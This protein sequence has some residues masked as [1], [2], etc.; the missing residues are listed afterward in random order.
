MA[1]TAK[2]AGLA[3]A[4]EP[5][6]LATTAA[7][8]V[9]VAASPASSLLNRHTAN[10]FSTFT[11]PEFFK[12]TELATGTTTSTTTTIEAQQPTKHKKQNSISSLSG[13]IASNSASMNFSSSSSAAAATHSNKPVIRHIT[14]SSTLASINNSNI[15]PANDSNPSINETLSGLI[16][17]P[18]DVWS[19]VI[20]R[21]IPLFNGEGH[22]GF[23]ED[24]NDFVSQHIHKTIADSPSKSIIKLHTDITEL[25][26]NGV[27]ILNNKLQ[28]DQLNDSKLLIKVL[29]VWHFFFTGVLP[30]LEAIFLPL[31][32]DQ[33]LLNMIE[34]KN[35]IVLQERIQ[36]LHLLQ[37]A[38]TPTSLLLRQSNKSTSQQQP[39]KNR[40]AHTRNDQEVIHGIDIRR[41]ALIAFREHLIVP[42]YSR[43]YKLFTMI[44][45]PSALSSSTTQFS[46]ETNS[47]EH[48]HLKRL[49]MIG[50]LCSVQT[51]DP[52]QTMITEFSKLIRFKK[53]NL[54]LLS[55]NNNIR[56]LPPRTASANTNAVPVSR[57]RERSESSSSSRSRSSPPQH[58]HQQTPRQSSATI[59]Q[60][61]LGLY[62]EEYDDD[63]PL[64]NL[65]EEENELHQIKGW[66]KNR[67]FA[68]RSIRR[69]LGRNGTTIRRSTRIYN[70]SDDQTAPVTN[71]PLT[72]SLSRPSRVQQRN[73][74]IQRS[75]PDSSIPNNPSPIVSTSTTSV[76]M[77]MTTS[78]GTHIEEEE[79]PLEYL[80][81]RVY[82]NPHSSQ[83]ESTTTAHHRTRIISSRNKTGSVSSSNG[84]ILSNLAPSHPPPTPSF[85]RNNNNTNVNSGGLS[86]KSTEEG[87]NPYSSLDSPQP[88]TS[89]T[90]SSSSKTPHRPIQAF[91]PLNPPHP[92]PSSNTTMPLNLAI[93]PLKL[94]HLRSRSSSGL[95][96]DLPPP[97][98]SSSTNGSGVFKVLPG[99]N[100]KLVISN[101]TPFHH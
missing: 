31:M 20:L 52:K 69:Q 47:T 4:T 65:L 58:Q 71:P 1:S 45:D 21:V 11:R 87:E 35:N 54:D 40:S 43:L 15:K 70:H 2:R 25:L 41:L 37:Q 39:L 95:S 101:P 29:E 55:S 9:S 64:V 88:T 26:S 49:Q 57:T 8:A 61:N 91:R 92:H 74:T 82:P 94:S 50:L 84:S 73:R 77:A 86:S 100:D 28:P 90:S 5:A 27:M 44:Y 32:S 23:I 53:S 83:I 7:T 85:N 60:S 38:S 17:K 78:Q 34:S 16:L 48:M 97:T 67:D 80:S 99:S 62:P 66:N 96:K 19:Q 18:G 59:N 79:Q 93:Q 6:S 56:N 24:L 12:R 98:S 72:N 81:D 36:Q 13:F 75:T 30:Y 89:S 42:I 3:V 46:T 33:N 22:K 51:D 14:S 10:L 76:A 68:R 63:R